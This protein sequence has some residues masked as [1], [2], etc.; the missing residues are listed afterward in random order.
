MKFFQAFV[1]AVVSL[2]ATAVSASECGASDNDQITAFV[3]AE[4]FDKACGSVM[5]SPNPSPATVCKDPACPK[6][7]EENLSKL[8]NCSQKGMNLR[9]A[10]SLIVKQ[11]NNKNKDGTLGESGASKGTRSCTM[12]DKLEISSNKDLVA[13]CKSALGQ[14]NPNAETFCKDTTCFKYM[15]NN[16][17]KLPDCAENGINLRDGWKTI[18]KQCPATSSSSSSSTITLGAAAALAPVVA[19][20]LHLV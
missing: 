4:A 5:S 19:T 6:Y 11:C 7:M 3:A 20:L 10:W 1:V 8:P 13:A 16:V 2:S 17:D 12:S 18:I 9:D 15:S 14:G